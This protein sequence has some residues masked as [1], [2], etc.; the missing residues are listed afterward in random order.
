MTTFDYKI[1]WEDLLVW[2]HNNPLIDPTSRELVM[3]QMGH[4]AYS[5][6]PVKR[7]DDND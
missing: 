4:I 2:L 3:R 7:E 5:R 1:M 6:I